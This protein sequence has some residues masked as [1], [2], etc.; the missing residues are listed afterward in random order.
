[1]THRRNIAERPLKLKD[2]PDRKAIV[3]IHLGGIAEAVR[4]RETCEN[5]R[6]AGV[7]RR[8]RFRQADLFATDFS[9][10]TVVLL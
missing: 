1:M 2:Q 4:I 7:E 10:A 6:C 8:V 9:P 5:A 3:I